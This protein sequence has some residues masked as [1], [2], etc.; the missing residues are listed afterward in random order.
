ML[1]ADGDTA[2]CDAGGRRA[3]VHAVQGNRDFDSYADSITILPHRTDFRYCAVQ[4]L[5]GFMDTESTVNVVTWY[6][7]Y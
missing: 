7:E 1:R 4:M 3:V 5:T 2:V 6:H